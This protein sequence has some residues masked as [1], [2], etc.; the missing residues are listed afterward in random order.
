[1]KINRRFS[2]GDEEEKVP[3]IKT[4][5]NP[6]DFYEEHSI[7]EDE[8]VEV[9]EEEVVSLNTE[10]IVKAEVGTIGVKGGK[11]SQVTQ[12]VEKEDID[13]IKQVLTTFVND[14]DLPRKN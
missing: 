5:N 3:E 14:I 4:E 10:V 9:K 6:D 12:A 8:L 1:M 7:S 11:F 13:L 2:K